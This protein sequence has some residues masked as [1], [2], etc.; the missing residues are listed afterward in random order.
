VADAEVPK[1]RNPNWARDELILALDL[2]LR[3][4]PTL[5]GD[6]DPD[7]V[8]LSKLLNDLPIHTVRPDQE[9]FRN[10]NGVALKLANL[11]ALDPMYPGAGMP[12]GGRLDAEVWDVW[13]GRPK[14][15]ALLAAT[16]RAAASQDDDTS[17]PVTP[18]EGEDEVEEGKIIF[19]LHRARERNQALAK[20]K[21]D[22]ALQSTGT[23][24]C[25]ACGFDFK[26][27][28]GPLGEGYIE[29]H[30]VIPLAELGHTKTKLQDLALL[31]ANCH[32]MAH[33]AKPWKSIEEIAELVHRP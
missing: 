14:E 3:R 11:A 23:L 22:K 13:N 32:R 26:L 4:R 15:L 18:E 19:R 28:Y 10:P 25:E 7:V 20:K 6:D 2:Y 9:R 17:A 31:C 8:E 24:T 5:P 12:R 1:T 33:R 27:T 29:R 30:H 16:L 21:K